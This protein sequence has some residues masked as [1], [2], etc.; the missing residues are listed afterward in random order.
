MRHTRN[1]DTSSSS[2][3]PLLSATL[4]NSS[5]THSF[6]IFGCRQAVSDSV[7]EMTRNG[8]E[9]KGYA[10]QLSMWP[11]VHSRA[12]AARKGTD[13]RNRAWCLTCVPNTFRTM[14]HAPNNIRA[15]CM[16]SPPTVL[17]PSIE[18]LSRRAGVSAAVLNE[19]SHD[20]VLNG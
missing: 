3:G 17:A 14:T 13:N 20:V 9:P 16:L 2:P 19:Q 15:C 6:R 4:R 5:V 8:T 11:L 12:N 1:A 10:T 7:P 18:P